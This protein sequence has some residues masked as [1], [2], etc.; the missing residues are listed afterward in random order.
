VEADRDRAATAACHAP[1]E[2]VIT[3]GVQVYIGYEA[4]LMNVPGPPERRWCQTR[5]LDHELHQFL[6]QLVN[7]G[8]RGAACVDRAESRFQGT[9]KR[10]LAVSATPAPSE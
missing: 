3:L 9:T 4:G 7:T 5:N 2:V 6:G 10:D 1:T 8:G